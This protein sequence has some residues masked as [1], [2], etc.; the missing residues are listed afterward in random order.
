ME[1]LSLFSPKAKEAISVMGLTYIKWMENLGHGAAR[2]PHFCL[3]GE[4]TLPLYLFTLQLVLTN[5]TDS[6]L[7]L[8]TWEEYR[9]EN[10]WIWRLSK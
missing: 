4:H 1:N 10:A 5:K 7:G 8:F 9:T 3:I 6:F 2:S